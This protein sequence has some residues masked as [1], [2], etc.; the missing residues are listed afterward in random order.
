[1]NDGRPTIRMPS[2]TGC[3]PREAGSEETGSQ[4]DYR[5]REG[6]PSLNE[7]GPP[8]LDERGPPRLNKRGPRLKEGEGS[9]EG[10]RSSNGPDQS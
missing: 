1:M 2:G 8:R 4:Y 5:S 3:K 9:Y 6:D 7:R 10:D